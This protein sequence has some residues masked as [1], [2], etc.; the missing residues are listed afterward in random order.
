LITRVA[1]GSVSALRVNEVRVVAL[2]AYRDRIPREA[3]VVRDHGGGLRAY[4]N[5][6]QHLPV[7]L[8]GGSRSFLTRNRQQLQCGTHGARFRL[9]DGYCVYG[10]C[11]GRSLSPIE[12]EVEGD[13]LFLLVEGGA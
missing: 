4:L 2:P 8:D 10:P 3:L 6:C 12:I 13:A 7:P 1:S 5:R 11:Q 9:E